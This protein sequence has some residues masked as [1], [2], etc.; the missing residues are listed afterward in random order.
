MTAL[1]HFAK[2]CQWPSPHEIL[3]QVGK[4]QTSVVDKATELTNLAV[5][6]VRKF[7]RDAA[8]ARES[9]PTLAWYAIQEWG[10]W[11]AWADLTDERMDI[12][13]SRVRNIIE[14]HLKT[15][16]TAPPAIESGVVDTNTLDKEKKQTEAIKRNELHDDPEKR[17]ELANLADTLAKNF[18]F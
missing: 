17:K 12:A 8:K 9:L 14:R 16:Q 18:G 1:H 10:G 5:A 6:G 13:R 11:T 7:G 4:G 15:G 2:R 3:E